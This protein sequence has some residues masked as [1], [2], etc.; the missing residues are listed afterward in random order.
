MSDALTMQMAHVLRRAGFGG[1][2][3]QIDAAANAG[4]SATV[5]AL[6]SPS[7][8]LS[9]LIPPEQVKDFTRMG[10]KDPVKWLGDAQVLWLERLLTATA[11]LREKMVLFWH[12]HFATGAD[13]LDDIPA[14]ARQNDLFRRM[15]LGKFGD[16]LLEV[17]RDPAMLVWLDGNDSRADAPN[18]NYGREVMELFTMGRGNYTEADV[19][20]A[21]RA[22][23]GWHIDD[24]TGATVFN[25]DDHDHGLK[26]FLGHTGDLGAADVVRI[27]AR[28]PETARNLT[29]KLWRHFAYPN[30]EPSVVDHLSR[31]YLGSDGDIREVLRAMFLHDRFYSEP[32]RTSLIKSPADFVVQTMRLGVPA[33]DPGTAVGA[34]PVMGQE[35]FNPPNVAGWPG[36]LAWINAGTLLARFNFASDAA[37][38][39]KPEGPLPG[40]Q[41]PGGFPTPDWL[42]DYWCTTLGYLVLSA[43]SRQAVLAY[44][45]DRVDNADDLLAQHRRVLHGVLSALE[46]QF[47]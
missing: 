23:T 27:L 46:F 10:D 24:A 37:Q 12:N 45:G 33:T 29:A 21:A 1:T 35:L 39:F 6:L 41:L 14:M 2:P 19:K 7:E 38:S 15:A 13:K 30:P 31:V 11:P 28:R 5:D 42:V 26:T 16:L 43:D 8:G 9:P 17:S 44:A 3:E 36:G 25:D 32:A 20:A 34:M 18:E 47:N 4:L 22:F 40:N